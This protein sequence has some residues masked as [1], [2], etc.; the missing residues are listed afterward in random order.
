MLNRTQFGLTVLAVAAGLTSSAGV[1]VPAGLIGSHVWAMDDDRHGGLSGLVVAADGLGFTALSDRRHFFEGRFLRDAEGRISGVADVTVTRVA[2]RDGARLRRR[3][4]DTEGLAQGPD[5]R[6]WLSL[7][8]PAQIARFNAPAA[9]GVLVDVPDAF[10]DFGRNASLESI[11]LDAAGRVYTIPEDAP[12]GRSDFPVWRRDDGGW[13]VVGAVPRAG[14]FLVADAAVGPDG[15]LYVLER[16][17]HGPF[18]F[19]SR[20]S[21][22]GLDDSFGPQEVLLTTTTGRHD[23]LEGLSIWRDA[24]G[25]L[26]ATMVS[27]DNFRFFQRTE[28]VEYRLPD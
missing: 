21:R 1:P 28:V 25:D 16:A 19:Q 18:G 22:F 23:N 7:E 26:I 14:G 24:A 8:D 3:A 6:L 10:A 17:F 27:D 15:R 4:L 12:D 2:G 9:G 13:R 5:G 11:A 20:L